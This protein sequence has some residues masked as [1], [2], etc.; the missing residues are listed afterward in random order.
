M[1]PSAKMMRRDALEILRPFLSAMLF[2]LGKSL[3]S[4]H[5]LYTAVNAIVVVAAGTLTVRD[6]HLA[7]SRRIGGLKE[8][9]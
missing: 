7:R 3:S 4:G 5:G 1:K 9:R 6:D 8:R 2:N